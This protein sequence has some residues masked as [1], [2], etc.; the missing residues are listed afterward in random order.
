[1]PWPVRYAYRSGKSTLHA[2]RRVF[3]N[4]A[5]AQRRFRHKQIA[6]AIK[7]QSF[8]LLLKPK[9]GEGGSGSTGC[10]LSRIAGSRAGKEVSLAVKSQ[11]GRGE[12][13][14]EGALRAVGRD[15]DDPCLL[16]Q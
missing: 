13:G 8:N 5:H 6:R 7:G 1:M 11:A 3:K 14:G 15:F 10:K 16:F 9:R 12:A 4:G 2:A